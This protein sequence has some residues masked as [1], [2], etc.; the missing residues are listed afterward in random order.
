MDKK[1]RHGQIIFFLQSE[2]PAPRQF[3]YPPDFLTIR[4][5]LSHVF[6]NR[7][8]CL[9]SSLPCPRYA[10]MTLPNMCQSCRW[11]I[12][13]TMQCW[14]SV[15]YRCIAECMTHLQCTQCDP[16]LKSEW[17][18]PFTCT[19]CVNL[20]WEH[21]VKRESHWNGVDYRPDAVS[22]IIPWQEGNV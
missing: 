4:Y 7:V 17:V 6:G 13:D 21:R 9:S 5:R 11:V 14:V 12:G 2:N 18:W 10:Q 8:E 22:V 1:L 3:S 20:Y 19:T 16:R 15:Y